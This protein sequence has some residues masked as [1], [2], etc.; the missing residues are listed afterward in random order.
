NEMG[1]LERTKKDFREF[2]RKEVN[3]DGEPTQWRIFD[4]DICPMV[5]WSLYVLLVTGLRPVC[6]HGLQMMTQRVVTGAISGRSDLLGQLREGMG[7]VS[8]GLPELALGMSV[9]RGM[10]PVTLVLGGLAGVA[11]W[12]WFY[13]IHE[14][15]LTMKANK[16]VAQ[17]MAK[18][19]QVDG[20][21]IYQLEE[22]IAKTEDHE[23]KFSYG[24][25]VILNLIN[26]ALNQNLWSLLECA[27]AILAA[28]CYI[29][30]QPTLCTLP[31]VAGLGKIL[32]GDY[33]GILPVALHAWRST[34]ENRR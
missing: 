26:L 27:M 18:N 34:S 25:A 1:F 21:V 10:T 15:A 12:C 17:S 9:V 32:R 2:F 5:S 20:E 11:H 8:I 14:A 7:N 33:L 13:P 16:I 4:L 23:K 3:M 19:T 22:K 28:L 6:L 29:R 24:V 31:V 30:G